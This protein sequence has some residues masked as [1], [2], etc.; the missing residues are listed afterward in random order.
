M[1]A[2]DV[3]GS[4]AVLHL[5]TGKIKKRK[6]REIENIAKKILKHKNIT[7]VYAQ[8]KI[9]GRFRKP[10]L[11]WIA[12]KKQT[13]TIHKESGC[14]IKLDIK[15]CYFSP[16]LSHDRLEVAK[17]V[18]KNEVVLVMFSGV[19][20]YALIIGKHSKP[21]EIYCI[22]I[23]KIASKYAKENVRLNKL[24]NIKIIQG[25]VK[26]IVPRLKKK[27]DRI[28][29]ARPQLKETFLKQA[30]MVSK[31]NTV[32]HFYDF[33]KKQKL[34]EIR[35]KI[36]REAKMARKKIKIIKINKVREIAPYKYHVRVDFKIT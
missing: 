18:K 1:T 31:K 34:K 9:W 23:S 33:L 36:E 17:K 14:I 29:M 16:R 2:F 25:D 11:R 20:P 26:R 10:K 27:F 15:N 5:K 30:F 19:A 21:K 32:I 4:I 22:E 12:G 35:T 6:R 24:D 3:I 13:K 28:I 8:I 7:S